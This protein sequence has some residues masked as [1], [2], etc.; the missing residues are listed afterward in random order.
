VADRRPHYTLAAMFGAA[1]VGIFFV[2]PACNVHDCGA[3]YIQTLFLALAAGAAIG[4]IAMA[5][6]FVAVNA[7]YALVNRELAK[8]LR[9]REPPR[10]GG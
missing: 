5:L 4:V 9:Q 8:K 3:D 6:F 10:H 1:A 7:R 2:H